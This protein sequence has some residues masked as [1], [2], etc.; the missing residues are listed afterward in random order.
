MRNPS[1]FA[2][3]RIG[4]NSDNSDMLNSITNSALSTS[5]SSAYNSLQIGGNTRGRGKLSPV[6]EN[7]PSDSYVVDEMIKE[8]KSRNSTDSAAASDSATIDDYFE[9]IQP[10]KRGSEATLNSGSVRRQ[11]TDESNHQIDAALFKRVKVPPAHSTTSALT[12]KL[13]STN[14]SSNPFSELYA[15]ISGRAETSTMEVIVFFPHAVSPAG[16]PLKLKVRKDATV[17]ETIGFSLWSYWEESWQPKLDEGLSDEQK[18]TKLSAVGW[19]LRIAEDDGEVDE[20][21][22]GMPCH[23]FSCLWRLIFTKLPIVRE[24]SR[25]STSMRTQ[26]SKLL[27]AKV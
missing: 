5:M 11:S 22:P 13:A 17:E 1:D 21:F 25:I 18:K 2:P 16:K 8:G 7:R 24:K 23:S 9:I 3:P 12:S 6:S 4:L 20:D 19:V 15:L 27:K 26:S 10:P 14:T